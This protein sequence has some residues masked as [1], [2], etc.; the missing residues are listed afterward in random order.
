MEAKAK[1]ESSGKL[2]ESQCQA[3]IFFKTTK[4]P[5]EYGNKVYKV[6]VVL[7]R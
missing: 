3:F 7:V 5:H 2:I 1:K 4:E 6:P